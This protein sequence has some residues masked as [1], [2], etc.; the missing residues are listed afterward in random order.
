LMVLFRKFFL[1]LTL[2]MTKLRVLVLCFSYYKDNSIVSMSIFDTQMHISY[3]LVGAYCLFMFIP[4]VQIEKTLMPVPNW[5]VEMDIATQ[6]WLEV[7]TWKSVQNP[8]ASR[9]WDRL[10]HL[11]IF[12]CMF[13]NMARKREV[14]EGSQLLVMKKS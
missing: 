12:Q 13:E 6:H 8:D 9:R 14:L 3:P 2:C 10:T 5:N 1:N 11:H 7:R 4:N